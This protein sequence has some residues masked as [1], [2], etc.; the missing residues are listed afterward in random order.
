MEHERKVH[1]LGS[2][3]ANV[4]LLL[5]SGNLSYA[6]SGGRQRMGSEGKGR[7]EKERKS[8]FFSFFLTKIL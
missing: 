1:N 7:N 8:S 6:E 5:E 3:V 2:T 4:P